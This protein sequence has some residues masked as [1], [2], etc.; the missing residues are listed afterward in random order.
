MDTQNTFSHKYKTVIV[1][2]RNDLRLS[3]NEVLYRA[4]CDAEFVLPVY[5]FDKRHF[6]KTHFGFPKTGVYRRQFMRESLIDLQYRLREMGGDLLLYEGL[7]EDILYSLA[8]YYKADAV[9]CQ[10]EA[11]EEEINTEDR[12]IARL[13]T[14][15]VECHFFWGQTLCHYDDLLWG[16]IENLP[17]RFAQFHT[18]LAPNF[19]VR[20][21]LPQPEQ[22][23]L[24]PTFQPKNNPPEADTTQVTSGKLDPRAVLPFKGG[25][26]NGLLRLKYY[27]W[28]SNNIQHY[29]QTRHELMCS[30]CS[31][32]LSPWLALGCLSPRFVYAELTRYEQ[33]YGKSKATHLLFLELLRRDFLRFTAMK[34]GNALFK[35]SG[36]GQKKTSNVLPTAEQVN[37]FEKWSQGKTGI[38]FIDANMRELNATGYMSKKGRQITASFLVNILH[39]DWRMGAEYFESLLLDYDVCSNYGN[40]NY[41][42]GIDDEQRESRPINLLRQAQQYDPKGEYVRLWCPELKKLPSSRIHSPY[43]LSEAEQQYVGVIIGR[44]YPPPCVEVEKHSSEK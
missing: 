40:W 3:D 16:D 38:P 17:N 29:E 23:R 33:E 6:E 26:T 18:Q 15:D 31:S 13:D 27:F 4:C 14:I 11:T 7:P 39:L 43:L 36:L 8:K 19:S 20:P 44:H 21:I 25:E 30:D 35:T 42:A 10:Q 5:C 41:A 22:L 1:W 2:L 12:L 28:E 34:Y 37:L 32:K 24:P 9:Y